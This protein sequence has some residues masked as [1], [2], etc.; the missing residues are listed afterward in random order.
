MQNLPGEL[1]FLSDHVLDH[2]LEGLG[3]VVTHE[4]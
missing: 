2:M 4:V 1:R 3:L